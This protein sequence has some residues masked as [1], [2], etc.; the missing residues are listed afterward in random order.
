MIR[1][2]NRSSLYIDT[3]SIDVER[4]ETEHFYTTQYFAKFSWI[5]L[6]QLGSSLVYFYVRGVPHPSRPIPKHLST[7]GE[8]IMDTYKRTKKTRNALQ[9]GVCAGA[10]LFGSGTLDAAPTSEAF[11]YQGILNLDGEMF[12]GQADLRFRLYDAAGGVIQVGTD[13]H[14]NG[15]MVSDGLIIADL[16]FGAGIFTGDER[17]LE[18]AIRTPSWDGTGDEPVFT[19]LN[20]LQAILPTPYALFA[21]N[22]VEGPVGPQGSTGPQG[23][24][25]PQGQQ[26]ITG[27]EGPQGIQ[28]DVGPNGPVGPEGPQGPMGVQGIQ[29]PTGSQGVQGPAGD[30]YW[31]FDGTNTTFINGNVGVGTNSPATTLSLQAPGATGQVGFTMNSFAGQKAM[32][33]QTEDT[34]GDLATRFVIRGGNNATDVQAFT[35]SLGSE[36]LLMHLEGDNQFAGFGREPSFN[37]DIGPSDDRFAVN[38]TDE[39]GIIRFGNET[40][41]TDLLS[42]VSVGNSE[43][44][45]DSNGNSSNRDFRISRHG[46][47]LNGE[48]LMRVQENGRVSIGGFD[49]G[50]TSLHVDGEGRANAIIADSS[51]VGSVS[52]LARSFATTGNSVAGEFRTESDNGTGVYAITESTSGITYGVRGITKSTDAGAAGVRGEAPNNGAGYGVYGTAAGGAAFGVYSNG[53]LGSSGTKSF[54][55]DHPLDPEN[56]FLY[57][58]ST[59]SPEVLNSYSGTITLGANGESWVELPDYFNAINIDPRYQLT[60][61]GAPA[62]MLHVASE[63]NDNEF[64]IAGGQPGMRVSWEVKA[65]RNDPFVAQLGA[66]VEREKVGVEKGRYLQPKLYGQPETMRLDRASSNG[67]N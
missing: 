2:R 46:T 45:I 9:L 25:G 6:R 18:I 15:A 31:N 37:L 5:C 47:G 54:M 32:E 21:L 14:L 55:I 10:L 56:K 35:G 26:G 27:P 41:E 20:P 52:L 17:W 44:V 24:V 65:K 67:E 58:Y 30:S 53:R 36:L 34:N 38:L 64:L 4:N 29:G 43:I 60:A 63:I 13:L 49:P 28:G 50:N 7:T 1:E 12:D 66:P 3:R 42:M 61:I 16:D 22:G 59:E 40:D 57:H 8:K 33:L 11:T 39:P 23:P 62:P 19:V 48:E 51:L